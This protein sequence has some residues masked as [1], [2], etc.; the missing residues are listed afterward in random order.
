MLPFIFLMLSAFARSPEPPP[1]PTPLP[2]V[3]NQCEQA[4]A[5]TAGI[6]FPS[7]LVGPGGIVTCTSLAVPRSQAGDALLLAEWG[8]AIDEW[9]RLE[10]QSI[11]ARQKATQAQ[12][13]VEVAKARRRGRAEGTAAGGG[14]GVAILVIV[15]AILL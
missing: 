15:L 13:K 6:E 1:R 7:E 5:L 2:A 12:N 14:V 8:D 11:E 9:Y 3:E 4:F 10:L